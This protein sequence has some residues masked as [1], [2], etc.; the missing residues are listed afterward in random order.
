ML[1]LSVL[2]F[3]FAVAP[4]VAYWLPEEQG[5]QLQK[6]CKVPNTK[7]KDAVPAILRT[8][9]D[10]GNNS[11]VVFEAGCTYHLMTPLQLSGLHNVELVFKGNISLPSNVTYVETVVNNSKIYPGHWITI[12][13]SKGVTLTGSKNPDEGNFI[14]HGQLW[15]PGGEANSLNNAR[16][17]FFS[18]DVTTLRL[19]DLKIVK[20]IAWVFALGGQ[21][22][23]MTNTYLDAKSD[24]GF[25]FNTDGID[26]EAND[27]VID[28]W[29]SWNGDDVINV[30]TPAKNITMRNVVA[31]G[32]HGISISCGSGSASDILFE[33]MQIFDSL[34]GTRFKGE[35]GTT[36]NVSNVTWRNFVVYNT[37]YPVYFTTTYVD[38]EVGPA[39]G[40]NLS[41]AAYCKD[42]TWE[43]I[44]GQTSAELGDGSCVSDPCWYATLG[45]SYNKG[46]YLL[47]PDEAHCQ[48]F[49]FKD[50]KLFSSS[51]E[52]A[53]MECTGLRGNDKMG[54]TCTNG[55]IT[56]N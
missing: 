29:V 40:A 20:P 36:C 14:G 31:W 7:G 9:A 50:V 16:P 28:G 55:T 42:F 52:T 24:D 17:H 5:H 21:D 27:V 22:I 18:F 8:V 48:N 53:Q 23:Y 32:T 33:N 25:P 30:G 45:Q 38:Q 3:L 6:Q 47:C 26:C 51:W 12:S 56:K 11:R 15:W 35:L 37:S 10:C 44:V 19:R 2:R 1:F 34:T 39:P 4:A 41:L 54:I 49:K 43:N 46:L 13:D